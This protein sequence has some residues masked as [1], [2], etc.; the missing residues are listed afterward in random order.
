MVFF[1]LSC[2]LSSKFWH[3][4]SVR[5]LN[6]VWFGAFPVLELPDTV[7]WHIFEPELS[8]KIR[9]LEW[10]SKWKKSFHATWLGVQ[11]A[12]SQQPHTGQVG[13]FCQCI[14]LWYKLKIAHFKQI[15]WMKNGL[16]NF[17]KQSINDI[18]VSHFLS[19]WYLLSV[20]MYTFLHA[21]RAPVHWIYAWTLRVGLVPF[22][23]MQEA[24]EVRHSL[25]I[26]KTK[27]HTCN[28][29]EIRRLRRRG[30]C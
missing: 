16:G 20:F 24:S 30:F 23:C 6:S 21:P 12:K 9:A 10:E 13:A 5:L 29:T 15:F 19:T 8:Q 2:S 11:V 17:I 7:V 1:F 27:N 22:V 4:N 28:K 3:W 25:N 14:L 18:N 26:L